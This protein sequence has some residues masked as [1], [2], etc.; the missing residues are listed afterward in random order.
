[1]VIKL[2]CCVTIKAKNMS[3]TQNETEVIKVYP[4]LIE[5][6]IGISSKIV[7]PIYQTT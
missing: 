1:M 2:N 6:N 5:V 4:V 3:E 7:L